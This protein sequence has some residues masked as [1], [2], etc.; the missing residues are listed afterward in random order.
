MVQQLFL[1]FSSFFFGSHHLNSGRI[2]NVRSCYSLQILSVS[3]CLVS[4]PNRTPQVF[5]EPVIKQLVF[6]FYEM[7]FCTIFSRDHQ[8]V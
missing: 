1:F 8:L 2:V 6:T 3:Y 4:G 7:H 5:S